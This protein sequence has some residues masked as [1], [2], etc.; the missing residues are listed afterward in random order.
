MDRDE[1]ESGIPYGKVSRQLGVD[2][3]LKAGSPLPLS[4]LA[5]ATG[6]ISIYHTDPYSW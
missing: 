2:S 3:V 1:G 6:N 5:H 4:L